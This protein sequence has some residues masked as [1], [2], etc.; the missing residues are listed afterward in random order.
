MAT[1]N[2]MQLEQQQRVGKVHETEEGQNSD[3]TPKLRW[4]RCLTGPA[5]R[6]GVLCLGC[7]PG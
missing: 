6:V 2:P 3:H 5:D 7:H 1:K 4:E